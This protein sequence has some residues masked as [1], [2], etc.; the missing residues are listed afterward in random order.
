M[1][2]KYNV[3]HIYREKSQRRSCNDV[4]IQGVKSKG[5]KKK[6]DKRSRG[7]RDVLARIVFYPS[8]VPN[9]VMQKEEEE[10]S[11]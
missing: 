3:A 8:V 11:S 7:V 1:H 5:R 10:R 4:E 9:V 2:N 6:A